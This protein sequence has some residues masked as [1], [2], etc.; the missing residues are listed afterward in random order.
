MREAGVPTPLRPHYSPSTTCAAAPAPA[1][2]LL[3]QCG[4][5]LDA[6]PPAPKP[7]SDAGLAAPARPGPVERGGAAEAAPPT[8]GKEWSAQHPLNS[9][10]GT[11]PRSN[12]TVT[13]GC[14]L[15]SDFTAYRIW[16]MTWGR[17]ERH[18]TES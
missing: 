17:G 15:V 14:P 18:V 5:L 12:S 4:H 7:A 1:R 11:K 9:Q 16:L 13:R 10:A 2:L 6:D 3:L 8:K